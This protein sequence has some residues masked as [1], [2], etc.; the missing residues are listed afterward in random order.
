M[1]GY[2]YFLYRKAQFLD[3]D[4][5]RLLASALIQCHYEYSCGSWYPSLTMATKAAA[6]LQVSQNKLIRFTL[7]LPPRTHLTSTHFNTLGWLPI[8]YHVEQ[9]KLNQIYRVLDNKA[10]DYLTRYFI[11]VPGGTKCTPSWHIWPAFLKNLRSQGME[12][13]LGAGDIIMSVLG[14][15]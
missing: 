4:T 8:K 7:K 12:Q 6:K 13:G 15:F 9:L 2:I 3:C 1:P 14:Y 10:P 11:V 5:R